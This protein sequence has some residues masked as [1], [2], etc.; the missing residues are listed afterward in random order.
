MGRPATR[1]PGRRR[2]AHAGPPLLVLVVFLTP[3]ALLFLGSLRATGVSPPTTIELVPTGADLSNYGELLGRSSIRRQVFNS[4]FVAAIAVPVG[5]LVAS[6]AGFAIARLPRRGALLLLGLTVVTATIPVSTLFVG[7]LALFRLTGV[8]DTPVPLIAPALI[9]VSPILVLLFAWAYA[10]IPRDTYD[11]ALEAG[12]GPLRTWWS[13]ALPIRMPVVGI[14]AA[15]AFMISWGDLV[16]PLLFVYDERWFTLPLGLTSLA[17]LPVTD[18]GLMLAAAVF[19]IA[20]V[21][22]T[23]VLVQRFVSDRTST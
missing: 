5:T 20:P 9:G 6:W 4:L 22:V 1:D 14:S 7:R 19:A 17:E 21:L 13:V 8:T 16:D 10:T 2:L 11:L 23:A 18:Q 12:L 3:L 15:V